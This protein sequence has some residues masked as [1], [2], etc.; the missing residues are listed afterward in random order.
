MD[1]TGALVRIKPEAINE[2]NKRMGLNSTDLFQVKQMERHYALVEC[3]Q[4]D[5]DG[6][7]C[8]AFEPKD[9][10]ILPFT[11]VEVP[12]EAV[13]HP[14]HY[15][16]SKFEVIDII[17]EFELGFSL[18]NAIKYVL[19]AGKKDPKKHTEDLEKAVWY[20]NREISNLK[21]KK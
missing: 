14:K 10:E 6:R 21:A 20:L 5:I 1:L 8:W 9:L 3:P 11:N 4:T 18:G 13:D 2:D 15:K 12:K 16:S 17:E 19:R 7:G